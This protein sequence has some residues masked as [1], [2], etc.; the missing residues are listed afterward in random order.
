MYTYIKKY[1]HIHTCAYLYIHMYIHIYVYHYR[2]SS[3]SIDTA[4][5]F[6]IPGLQSIR[7][8]QSRWISTATQMSGNVGLWDKRDLDGK[9]WFIP[10]FG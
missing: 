3:T 2:L 1:I 4:S 8:S 7:L 9:W 5:D 10:F 6:T